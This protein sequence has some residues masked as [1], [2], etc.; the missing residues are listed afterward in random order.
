M[1][2]LLGTIGCGQVAAPTTQ[3]GYSTDGTTLPVQPS[4]TVLPTQPSETLLPTQTVTTPSGTSVPTQTV[5]VPV[6]TTQPPQDPAVIAYNDNTF[7]RVKDYIPDIVVALRYAGTDNFMGEAIYDFQDA[8]LRYG[9]VKKLMKVQEALRKQGLSLKIWDAFRPAGAQY[10]MWD[11]HP[12][13]T[14]IDN[15]A[16][17]F[18]SHTMGDTVD[19]TLVDAQGNELDM[20]SAYDVFSKQ[21]DREY[22]D[23][24]ET[25]KANAKLLEDLMKKYGFS[26][27]REEWWHYSDSDWYATD[28]NFDPGVVSIWYANCSTYLTLR[29]TPYLSGKEIGRVPAGESVILLG[30]YEKFAYVDYKGLQGYVSSDYLM[31]ESQWLPSDMLSVVQVTVTYTYE[32]MQQ[33]IAALQSLYP[34]LLQVSSI[35]KSELGKDLTLLIVGDPNAENHVIMHASIHGREYVTSWTVMAMVEYWLSQG[36]AGCENTCFHIIPMLNP[37]G[38]YIAQTGDLNEEQQAIYKNDRSKGYTS[39]KQSVYASMWKSNG[40]GV[41]LNRNFDAAWDITSG[42]A[43]P[44]SERY[45]GTEPLSAAESAALAKY[46]VELMPDVTISWH[47]TGSVIYYEYG[48]NK[49]VNAASK[50][51]GQAVEAVCGNPLIGASGLDAAGYKD[52]CMDVLGIPS[53]TMELGCGACPL[54]EREI[55]SIFA[56]N[57][58]VMPAI[59]QWIE[60][61]K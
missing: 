34:A 37:D 25:Q 17:R 6:D 58:R 39:Y 22:S 33:D 10:I 2:T 18:S 38:V 5:T 14:Y 51:L 49:D 23:C 29:K 59:S 61:Q 21:G 57:L 24:T 43:K 53:L 60:Q 40:L 28:T 50:S 35:G 9:T 44:S 7:V 48:K 20:P 31:P 16:V 26:G 52:W 54:P 30:W 27:Y 45:K 15:P 12:D 56:R 19:V 32:Q 8:Y 4:E 47:A 13:D 1:V 42:R 55:Y 46:T 3:P 41:D 11:A 36:M